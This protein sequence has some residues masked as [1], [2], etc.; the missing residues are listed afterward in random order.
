[1][2]RFADRGEFVDLL[3]RIG[4]RRSLLDYCSALELL[5]IWGVV[6]EDTKW[7]QLLAVVALVS[8]YVICA[9]IWSRMVAASSHW[10]IDPVFREV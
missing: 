6:L 4:S 1:V 10:V 9:I 8:Q 3:C 5:V 7:L 2:L